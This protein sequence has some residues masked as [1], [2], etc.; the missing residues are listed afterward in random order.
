MLFSQQSAIMGGGILPPIAYRSLIKRVGSGSTSAP[1]PSGVAV[2][3]L[4][5]ITT[6][7]PNPGITLGTS[8]GDA[9]SSFS[10]SSAGTSSPIYW[11]L[12]NSTDVANGWVFSDSISDVISV[13]YEGRGATTLTSRENYTGGSGQSTAPFV[14]FVPGL[15][16]RGLISV[17]VDRDGD[18]TP[19]PPS[20]FSLRDSTV[21]AGGLYMAAVADQPLGYPGGPLVWTNTD[22]ISGNGEGAILLEAV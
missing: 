14:G 5:V 1:K 2:G 13:A 11:K 16:H 19:S 9:W 15:D 6:P 18:A 21:Y 4:V 20:L 17:I 10:V 8:G 3:D 22:G 7:S 12:L